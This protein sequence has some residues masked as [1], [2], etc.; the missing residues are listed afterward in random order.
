MRLSISNIAWSTGQDATVAGLLDRYGYDAIDV[1]P[2]KYFPDFGSATD[3]DLAR[4]RGWWADRNIEIVGM[5]SLLFGTEGLNLFG[6]PRTQQRMLRHLEHVCRIGQ[7]LGARYLVFG[8]PRNRDRTGLKD[9]EAIEIAMTFF[10][11]LG[12]I[13][14]GYDTT[15][16][17]EPNPVDY[18]SNFMTDFHSTAEVV[19]AVGHDAVRVQLDIGALTMNREGAGAVL[20]QGGELVAHIHAS[21]PQLKVLGDCGTEHG[22]VASAIRRYCPDRVVTIEMREDPGAPLECVER[23]LG[24]AR[25]HY[26]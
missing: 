8:S 1:A 15:I 18:G 10:G 2:S 23:A 17:L 24:Y 26:G 12:D 5:Q 16:C 3:S 7:G 19:R 13:A 25:S 6:D 11:R 14:A 22:S 4:V 9:E 20:E 21:E